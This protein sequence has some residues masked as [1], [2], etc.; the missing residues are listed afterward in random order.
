[1]ENEKKG[2]ERMKTKKRRVG[3]KKWIFLFFYGEGVEKR[4]IKEGKNFFSFF[5]FT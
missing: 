5:R 4:K 2:G 1:V 3:E